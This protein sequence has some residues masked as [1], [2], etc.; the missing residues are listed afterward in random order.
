M[1]KKDGI[2]EELGSWLSIYSSNQI[3]QF[4][5]II[6][7]IVIKIKNILSLQFF[8]IKVSFLELSDTLCSDISG[9]IDAYC[10]YY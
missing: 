3:I 5:K 8:V 7:C 2:M 10:K 4:A 9:I 1:A 6:V